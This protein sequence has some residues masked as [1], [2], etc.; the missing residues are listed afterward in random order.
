[1]Q[2]LSASTIN[3]MSATQIQK[4]IPFKVWNKHESKWI[5]INR[6]SG[7]YFMGPLSTIRWTATTLK[8]CAGDCAKVE[9]KREADL[10]K[11]KL[12][13]L[14]LE[15][16]L[17]S[18][19]AKITAKRA[20]IK[21]LENRND[22]E[23]IRITPSQLDKFNRKEI[24]DKLYASNQTGAFG[25]PLNEHKIILE[26][27]DFEHTRFFIRKSEKDGYTKESFRTTEIFYFKQ[28]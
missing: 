15:D 10:K 4:A 18:V 16:E 2:I 26:G 23:I 19:H 12:A 22:Y 3:S 21:E 6:S 13:L 11:A 1:M 7:S 8:N 17:K 24:A 14:D 25:N 28:F 27:A 9:T 20:E 5:E